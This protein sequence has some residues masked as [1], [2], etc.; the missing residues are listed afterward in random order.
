MSSGSEL[1]QWCQLA[2]A[3][4]TLCQPER[5]GIA[6]LLFGLPVDSHAS[7]VPHPHTRPKLNGTPR[8]DDAAGAGWVV[9][10]RG[11]ARSRS[12]SPLSCWRSRRLWLRSHVGRGLP[13]GPAPVGAGCA[14]TMRCAMT[15][16]LYTELRTGCPGLDSAQRLCA[17]ALRCAAHMALPDWIGP[18][19]TL[20]LMRAS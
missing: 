15:L 6:V 2:A 20:V 9:G 16:G 7:G 11:A 12:S 18:A 5:R 10:R 13:P 19:R 17:G 3:I 14:Q 1:H 8:P 4:M